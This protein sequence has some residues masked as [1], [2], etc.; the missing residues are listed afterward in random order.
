MIEVF[1]RPGAF[2]EVRSRL[3]ETAA[4]LLIGVS[5]PRLKAFCGRLADRRLAEQEWLESVASLVR[6]KPPSKWID[7]DVTRFREELAQLAQQ[8][9][10]VVNTVFSPRVD[11]KGFKPRCGSR[12]HARMASKW[13]ESLT[14]MKMKRRV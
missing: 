4:K 5:E 11:G 14:W 3:A 7:D 1:E 13:N 9:L 6:A 12:S 10:R 8:F 2:D